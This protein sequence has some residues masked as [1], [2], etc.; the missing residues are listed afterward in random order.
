MWNFQ[1]EYE[2]M[3]NIHDPLEGDVNDKKKKKR[4]HGHGG[5]GP[6]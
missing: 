6:R 3:K 2:D 4:G 5:H 1:D